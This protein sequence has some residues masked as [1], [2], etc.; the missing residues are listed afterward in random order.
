[1]R[2]DGKYYVADF[3]LTE[4]R[5]L[6]RSMREDYRSP[7][8]NDKW[9]I[10]TLQEL[11]EW[12]TMLNKDYPREI[13]NDRKYPVGLYIELKDYAD[14]LSHTGFDGAEELHALLAHYGLGTIADCTDK[15][16]IIIQS[17]EEPAL[18]KIASL[19]DLPL[20]RCVGY[21]ET[22]EAEWETMSLKYNAVGANS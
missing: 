20:V 8:L 15:M 22:T 19:S 18:D 9:E 6:K 12:V 14:N 5:L 3:T 17:F 13:G 2:S 7:F 11:I 21:T 10:L 1:M 4:L 16:P